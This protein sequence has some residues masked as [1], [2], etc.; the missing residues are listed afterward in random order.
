MQNSR[1]LFVIGISVIVAV[2]LLV[3]GIDYLKGI[4]VFHSS[5][6]YYATYTNVTG[7][8]V[9]AP[10][11]A[12][13]F[14]V[15]QVRE[16]RYQ[17]DNPGYVTAELALDRE[18]K[19]PAGTVAV[20]AIDMLGTASIQLKMPDSTD[21]APVGSELQTRINAGLME[22]LG[23]DLLPSVSAMVPKIDSLLSAVT[24]LVSDPALSQSIKRLDAITANLEATT[25]AVSAAA[26][27]LPAVVADARIIT[28]N[29]QRM[30]GHLDSL[31]AALN[32]MPLNETMENV[33]VIT[34]NLSA[35]TAELQS[36][37]SSIGLL[38]HDPALYNNLNATVSS[39]DSLF[40]DIKAHPKR[41]LKFSV[42]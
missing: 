18:L 41:Y 9:S 2:V 28:G 3:C 29:L 11:T 38:L 31:T 13:G 12:N 7:L 32:A 22:S 17:Y 16:I 24:V 27:P 37:D 26:R 6:Y 35:L 1:K 30:S 19:V 15:G 42:F 5:N 40:I 36:S 20:L 21:Y 14:K 8:S 25:A 33:K 4:N 10:V 39:L 34:A 23:G